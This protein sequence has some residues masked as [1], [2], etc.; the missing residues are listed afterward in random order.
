MSY[1]LICRRQSH[2]FTK[3]V[4][5]MAF[6]M[7]NG[8]NHKRTSTLKY[9]TKQE[10]YANTKHGSKEQKEALTAL[11]KEQ[12]K[13]DRI[14]ENKK[15]KD[16]ERRRAAKEGNCILDTVPSGVTF[17]YLGEKYLK[18]KRYEHKTN[19]AYFR[20]EH[21]TN[22]RYRHLSVGTMVVYNG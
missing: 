6:N 13:R 12:Y 9:K 18:G 4:I 11:Y 10:V 16:A 21:T 2:T 17:S 15:N 1:C 7:T 20:C 19:G 8:N 22:G 5:F 14:A 3:G